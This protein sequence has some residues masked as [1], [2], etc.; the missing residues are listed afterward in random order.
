M[1]CLCEGEQIRMIR[2]S[3]C[4]YRCKFVSV[5][6]PKVF[7]FF[8]FVALSGCAPIASI[9]PILEKTV[10]PSEGFA[11]ISGSF[12]RVNSG[13]FA[14]TITNLQTKQEYGLPL[15]EDGL[16]PKDV[17]KNIVAIKVPPGR[18]KVDNWYPYGTLTKE[19]HATFKIYNPWLSKPFEVRKDSVIFL[20]DFFISTYGITSIEWKVK[21]IKIELRE[22]KERF[23]KNYSEFKLLKFECIL[24]D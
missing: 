20:G 23:D 14:F 4:Y 2:I 15:G 1:L 9:E 12:T 24:C 13:G 22:A 17:T 10:A 7:T 6:L 3:F 5:T 19:K 11:Y 16:L 21:P 18:Y 8:I